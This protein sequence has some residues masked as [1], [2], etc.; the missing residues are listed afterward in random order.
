MDVLGTIRSYGDYFYLIT[1]LWTFLEGETFVL[2]AGMAAAQGVLRID[3]LLLCAWI[4]SFCGDQLYFGLGRRFGQRLVNRFPRLKP[5]IDVALGWLDRYATGFVLAY[6]FIF[7]IRNISSFAMGMS[8]M[9]WPRFC[10]FNLIAALL[11]AL[12]FA[13][14]GYVFGQAMGAMLADRVTD[15][16]L[17]MLALFV[18]IVGV[19]VL[20]DQRRRRRRCLTV[21]PGGLPASPA[22]ERAPAAVPRLLPGA[23]PEA[24]GFQATGTD[25]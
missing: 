19:K 25:S 5:R 10:F 20:L 7:G 17:S 4:G 15:F 9:P 2:F 1:F 24:T 22:A 21:V 14:S 13:G 23:T 8:P 18:L 12:V 3:I 11:W 6:R 16:L